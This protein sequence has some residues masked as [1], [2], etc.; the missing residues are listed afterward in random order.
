[1]IRNSPRILVD[2]RALATYMRNLELAKAIE[3]TPLS[4]IQCARFEVDNWPMILLPPYL[5]R[6][7]KPPTDDVKVS[8]RFKGENRAPLINIFQEGKINILGAYSTEFAEK[9]YAFFTQLFTANWSKLVC[10][11]PRRDL[12][13]RQRAR[14]APKVPPRPAPPPVVKLS[15]ADVTDILAAF[16]ISEPADA[17]AQPADSAV[18]Q[19]DDLGAASVP[20]AL[21]AGLSEWDFDDDGDGDEGDED[22]AM[23]A[24]AARLRQMRTMDEWREQPD[25][26]IALQDVVLSEVNRKNVEDN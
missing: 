11:Q 14:A 26:A 13:R 5:V 15:D 24:I 2:L 1:V 18:A 20:E 25:D 7:T 21:L 6:E 4:E 8:F 17:A 12:E 10:L 16:G 3:G 23:A 9:V 19:K 22:P